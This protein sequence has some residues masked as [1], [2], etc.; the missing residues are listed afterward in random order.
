MSKTGEKVQISAAARL[1]AL[2][3]SVWVL[4]EPE[5]QQYIALGT[6]DERPRI[7][8]LHLA[9]LRPATPEGLA[10]LQQLASRRLAGIPYCLERIDAL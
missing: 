3:D 9:T 5:T 4:K 1:K 2:K 7:T 10:E 8:E 6:D